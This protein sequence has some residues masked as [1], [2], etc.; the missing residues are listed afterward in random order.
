MLAFAREARIRNTLFFD[1]G[2]F[3]EPYYYVVFKNERLNVMTFIMSR[4]WWVG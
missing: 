2:Q 4:S 3:P 1:A